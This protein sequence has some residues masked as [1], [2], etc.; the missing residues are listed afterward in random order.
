MG[1]NLVKS[2]QGLI[3]GHERTKAQKLFFAIRERKIYHADKSKLFT[4]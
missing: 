2:Y 3:G 4:H 1:V